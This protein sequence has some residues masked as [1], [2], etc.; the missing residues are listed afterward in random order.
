MSYPEKI[1][2]DDSLTVAQLIEVLQGYPQDAKAVVMWD[3]GWSKISPDNMKM[4]FEAGNPLAVLVLDCN[5]YGTANELMGK[6]RRIM[7]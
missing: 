3:D 7:E 6:L 1:D 5:I 4:H 2:D